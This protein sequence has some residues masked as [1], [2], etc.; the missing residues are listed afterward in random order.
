MPAMTRTRALGAELLG[1]RHRPDRARQ[2]A[3]GALS[4][5]WLHTIEPDAEQLLNDR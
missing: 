5:V 2:S 4:K 1:R 3:A